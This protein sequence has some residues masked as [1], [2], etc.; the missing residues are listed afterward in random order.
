MSILI[1]SDI[2]YSIDD[3]ILNLVNF[4]RLQLYAAQYLYS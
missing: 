4:N 2:H 3:K 1:F